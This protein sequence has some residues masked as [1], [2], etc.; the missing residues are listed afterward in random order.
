MPSQGFQDPLASQDRGCTSRIG[1]NRQYTGLRNQS[2]ALV[3][4]ELNPPEVS[5]LDTGMPV[6]TGQSLVEESVVG[7]Q[8]IDQAAVIL[9]YRT[10]EELRFATHGLSQRFVKVGKPVRVGLSALQIPQLQPL[11][12]KIFHQGL[13]PGIP[14][15][16]L[17]LLSQDSRIVEFGSLGQAE[18]LVVGQA[19]PEE[20]GKTRGE[21]I[22][23][24][25]VG[26][27]CR[28]GLRIEFKSEEEMGR[29][30]DSLQ[31]HLD[32]AFQGLPLPLSRDCQPPQ[33]VDLLL[34]RRP[35]VGS[36]RQVPQYRVGAA[37]Q[38]FS[39]V[40]SADQ[41]PP[42]AVGQG[43][44]LHLERTQDLHGIGIDRAFRGFFHPVLENR[45]VECAAQ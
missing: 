30:Q 25:G 35:A 39:G 8:K 5:A 24:Q 13:G 27:A 16:P 7:V 20:V 15:H 17:N 42:M 43:L 2:P 9:Q 28:V 18:Q 21:L 19:A 38:V 23:P 37:R 33:S 4:G 40:M 29:H 12:G 6:M 36:Q 14:E 1:G 34:G 41:H 44:R 10:E 22:G 26:R 45:L 32:S 3:T 31:S 11:P